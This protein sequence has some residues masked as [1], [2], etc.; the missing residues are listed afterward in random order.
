MI[1]YE[2]GHGAPRGFYNRLAS[3]LVR[4]QAERPNRLARAIGYLGCGTIVAILAG[5]GY[6]ISSIK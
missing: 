5:V 6:A 1:R 2:P 4:Q 3:L